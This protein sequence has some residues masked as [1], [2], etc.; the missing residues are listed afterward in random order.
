MRIDQ[1]IA[2]VTGG[3][4]G[5]GE[6]TTR[7]I[8]AG[9]RKVCITCRSTAKAEALVEELGSDKVMYVQADVSVEEQAK[10]VVDEAVKRFGKITALI[11]C[12]GVGPAMKILPKEGGV[13]TTEMWDNVINTNLTGGFNMIRYASYA[14]K[15]NEP[16]NEDGERGGIISTISFAV[17]FGQVGQAAYV[18]SKG[19]L[20]AMTMPIARELARYGIRCNTIA[21]GTILTPMT[22]MLSEKVLDGLIKSSVFPKRLG[23]PEEFA[24]IA[25]EILRN[26]YING[27]T[28]YLDGAMRM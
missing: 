16:L 11:N 6:A 1:V 19:G 23:K 20:Q 7:A 4:T 28:I 3:A 25:M 10:H 22:N 5:M 14:M 9:G 13:H 17:N 26:L 15:D 12:A 21:P 27:T 18:A 8:V 2:I 24:S